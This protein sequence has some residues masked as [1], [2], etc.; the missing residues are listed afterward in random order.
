MNTQ[1]DDAQFADVDRYIRLQ[2][3][4]AA[5]QLAAVTNTQ[6]RLMQVLR[7]PSCSS[8]D[9]NGADVTVDE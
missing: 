5:A 2:L 3:G 9:D 7:A 8:E 1:E 4:G 6:D